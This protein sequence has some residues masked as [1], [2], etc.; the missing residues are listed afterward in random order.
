M[1]SRRKPPIGST[2]DI[3][4]GQDGQNQKSKEGYCESSDEGGGNESAISLAVSIKKVEDE[5]E[6]ASLWAIRV[7]NHS[8]CTEATEGKHQAVR[9]MN[10]CKKNQ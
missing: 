10:T 8:E 7:Y 3:H 4:Q 5:A 9:R 1:D 2:G 6:K